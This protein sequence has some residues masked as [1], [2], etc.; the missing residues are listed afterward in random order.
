M[1]AVLLIWCVPSAGAA[2]T[3]RAWAHDA[4]AVSEPSTTWYLAEG[5]TAEGFE[6]WVL[7]Q[8]PGSRAAS[9]ELT[10]MTGKGVSAGPKFTLAPFSRKTVDVADTLRAAA[11]VSTIVES[12]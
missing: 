12:N 6:T 4:A 2:A 11:E 7:V 10:Y 1:F 3:T 8:N 9:V 5:C